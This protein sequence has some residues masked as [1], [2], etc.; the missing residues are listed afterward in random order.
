MS[1]LPNTSVFKAVEL[2]GWFTLGSLVAGAAPQRCLNSIFAPIVFR[3]C[4]PVFV[5][6]FEQA[7]VSKLVRATYRSV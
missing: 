1:F 3:V 7:S 2:A 5:L 4:V 6:E